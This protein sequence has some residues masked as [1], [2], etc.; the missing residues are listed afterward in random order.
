[1]NLSAWFIR[2]PVATFLL[3]LGLLFVGVASYTQLPIAGVP[4]VDIP[5]ISVNTSLPG[6][7]AET[8][9]SSIT[10][11]LERAL[12]ILPGVTSLTSSSSLGVSSISVQFDLARSVDAAALDVQSA[13]NA[14]LGDLPK[15]LPHPPTF[16]KKNPSDALLMTIAVYA[17]HLPIGQVDDYVEN[18][19]TPELARV[20]G[21]GAIDYH[22]QQKPAVRIQID[23]GRIASMGLTMEDV[24]QRISESTANG[25]KGSLNGDR[26]AITLDTSDQLSVAAQYGDIALTSRN[27]AIVKLRDVGTTIAGVEDVRQSAWLGQHQ[28][29][30]IDVHKQ[31]GFNVN[32][33]V[34]SIK[35]VLPALQR[36]LPPSLHLVLLGDRTQTIR[37]SVS[38]VQFTLFITCLLVVLVVY[39]FLGS[40]RATLIPAIVIPL[41]LFGTMAAMYG[42]GY[43]LD[44]VS[45]MALTISIG[46]VVD[47]AIVML[48]NILRHVE[49][50]MDPQAAAFQGSREIGFTIFSMT[51]SLVAVFIPLLFM[52]GVVGRLFR[53]FADTVAIA[54]LISGVVSLTLTPVLCARFLNPQTVHRG[55]FHQR[56]EKVLERLRQGYA[57][58]L[59]AVLRH[60][61]LTLGVML[62]TLVVTLGIYVYIPKGFF[63][64][65]DN[66]LIAGVTEASP[67]ISYPAMLER[68]QSLAAAVRKDD[69]V[70]NV[71][72][73]IEGDPSTNVGRLLIDLKPFENRNVSVYQ[74]IDRIGKRVKN[75][76]EITLHMQARQDLQIGARVSKTQ[77]QY[78]LRD[79]NL[80]ELQQ[81]GPRML[82]ALR[83]LPELR[84]VEGD[85][86]PTAP[87]LQIVLDRDAMARL[88]VN[89]QAVDD[90]LYDA[91]GQRQV[92]SFY[93]QVSIYRVILEVDPRFQLDAN[94]LGRIYVPSKSG[95][96]VLL[97]AI[98]RL[99][100]SAAPLT[101]NHD[102]QFPATTLSFNLAPGQ[103]LGD[104]INAI[105]AKE[106]SM[107]KPAGLSSVFAGSAQ[108]FQESLANQ[109]FLILAALLTIYIVLGMLYESFIHPITIMSTLPS[110]GIG[111]LLALL[112]LHYDFSLVALIGIMLLIGIVKKNGIMMVDV[113]IVEE[114]AGLSPEEAIYKACLLR[115]RPI[116]MTTMVALLGALPLALGSGAGSELRRPLGIAMVGGLLLSQVLTLYTTPV[117]YLY[118]DRLVQRFRRRRLQGSGG[119]I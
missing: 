60:Q 56:C 29:V 118:M 107:A 3:M 10:S 34:A 92:A 98:S 21:V 108:A 85:S 40:L 77:F 43:T 59:R 86:Q 32:A 28:A 69:A 66:G 110:A 1:M 44:N 11:P 71:Y 51:I 65:Q 38:D 73:S 24:R 17:D 104:A 18:F 102:G 70:E 63:P 2:R 79:A 119:E 67:D 117:V 26:Q 35:E 12:A 48:E 19:L 105:N 50:G 31:I 36:N 115:F 103:A 99:E 82:A 49:E 93:T 41:S 6:A 96:P 9:A 37:S 7:S 62:A 16:E 61:P 64:Q 106:R 90:T 76:P 14:A 101:V 97:S 27:G 47:D 113:A 112:L 58:G 23:P 15:D 55:L 42:L 20:R 22:G 53:E 91:F 13:I 116:M 100:S 83:T 33:T 68:M 94:A 111:G 52:G 8:V 57:R 109:P 39:L 45:L 75:I 30:M 114:N 74:V 87:R 81:W 72:F 46:F 4:Q 78:T 5:T 95:V 54:I 89:V 84:D 88:G 25:P 80:A